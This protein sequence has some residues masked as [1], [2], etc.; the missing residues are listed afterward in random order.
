[1]AKLATAGATQGILRQ[2]AP[3]RLAG[4][5]AQPVRLVTGTARREKGPAQ[6]V[7]V[8]SAAEL[9]TGRF[10]MEGGAVQPVYDAPAG[11]RCLAGPAVPVY[12]VA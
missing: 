4:H 6:P 2:T 11:A 9:A 5:R 10:Q 1:M 8:V 7:Y 12:F 3:R